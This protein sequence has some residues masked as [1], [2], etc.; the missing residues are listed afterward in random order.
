MLFQIAWGGEGLG[1]EAAGVGLDL[2]VGHAV[3]VEVG[4]GCEALAA[5][6]AP[7]GLLSSV[8]PPVHVQA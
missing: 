4:G 2:L 6:L 5:C 3:V 1:A 7:V 8:N